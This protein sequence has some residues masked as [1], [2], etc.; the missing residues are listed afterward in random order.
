MK[1][2]KGKIILLI[3]VFYASPLVQNNVQAQEAYTSILQWPFESFNLAHGITADQNNDFGSGLSKFSR[4]SLKIEHINMHINNGVNPDLANQKSL[5]FYLNK[6][7]IVNELT[8]EEE[9]IS[10]EQNSRD[11]SLFNEPGM[12]HIEFKIERYLLDKVSNNN[13]QIEQ[14]LKFHSIANLQSNKLLDQLFPKKDLYTFDSSLPVVNISPINS[15][16]KYPKID[17]NLPDDEELVKRRKTATIIQIVSIPAFVLS[18]AGTVYFKSEADNY[19]SLHQNA[20]T[21][22]I[23]DY[24]YD[25]TSQ[26]DTYTYIAGGVAIVSLYS[27][28]HST[29]V[30]RKTSKRMSQPLY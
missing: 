6:K 4:Q 27:F 17:F 9:Y 22:T 21:T 28:I 30:K 19:Y 16:L 18:T 26:Y 15:L 13:I 8:N 29:I 1:S 3:F 11:K 12:N 10:W 2:H 7:I 5:V 23:A 24:N 14:S 25:K 20:L